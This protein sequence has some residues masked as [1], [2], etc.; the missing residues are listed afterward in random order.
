MTKGLGPGSQPARTE[1][2]T[3]ATLSRARLPVARLC[4]GRTHQIRRHLAHLAHHVLG[5]S[6]YGK[7]RING[8]F[9]ATYGL[10]RI[11]LH[12]WH[13]RIR[14]PRTGDWLDLVDPLPE[15]LRACLGRMEDVPPDVL[16]SIDA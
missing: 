9:R 6:N 11:F 14:H 16:A 12:A 15:D 4:T 13:L 1:F 8:W 5:D 2:R 3:L 7:G 10:P